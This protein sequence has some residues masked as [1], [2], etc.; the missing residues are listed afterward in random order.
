MIKG[1]GA[2]V[3][4]SNIMNGGREAGMCDNWVLPHELKMMKYTMI[5]V[6]VATTFTMKY[7]LQF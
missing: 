3:R 5:P 2:S 1:R 6:Y 4:S 7:G